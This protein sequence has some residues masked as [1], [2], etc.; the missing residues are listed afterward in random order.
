MLKDKEH[1][2]PF[3]LTEA[4]EEVEIDKDEGEEEKDKGAGRRIFDDFA[5]S[6]GEDAPELFSPAFVLTTECSLKMR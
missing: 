6:G 5:L 2:A 4:L 3:D 1:F